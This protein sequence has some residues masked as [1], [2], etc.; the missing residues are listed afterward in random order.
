VGAVAAVHFLDQRARAGGA[1]ALLDFIEG[2][3]WRN[4]ES[5]PKIG[6]VTPTA[7]DYLQQKIEANHY[8]LPPLKRFLP[9]VPVSNEKTC[10]EQA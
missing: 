6:F 2:F 8:N 10:Q 3:V 1:E 9:P 7:T 5:S 4:G